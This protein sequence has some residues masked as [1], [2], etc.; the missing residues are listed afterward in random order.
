MS[1]L[2]SLLRKLAERKKEREDYEGQQHIIERYQEKKLSSD[3]RELLRWKEKQRQIMIKEQLRR[4]RKKEQEELWSGRKN[5]PIY[6]KNIIKDNKELLRH[7]NLFI[8][9]GKGGIRR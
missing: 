3:E 2:K 1:V 7:K 5:N 4:I 9:N 6:E 8:N